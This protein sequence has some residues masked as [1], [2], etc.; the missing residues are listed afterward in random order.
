MSSL[1]CR[2]C[3]GPAAYLGILGRLM[4]FRCA[5]CGQL[6]GAPV[7][8]EC[9]GEPIVEDDTVG[10]TYECAACIGPDGVATGLRAPGLVQ[11]AGLA[12]GATM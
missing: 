7:C 11:P 10:T 3:E 12:E 5:C 2:H 6:T 4:Y 1:V 9:Y 8:H